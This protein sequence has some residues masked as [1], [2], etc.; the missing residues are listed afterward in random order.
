[1]AKKK[2]VKKKATKKKATKKKCS[3]RK[4][5]KRKSIPK[6]PSGFQN[7]RS[8]LVPVDLGLVP[9]PTSKIKTGLKKAQDEIKGM[10]Q[11]I[12]DTMTEDYSIKE[13]ELMA[14]FSADGKFLGIGVG[15]ATS[16]KITIAPENN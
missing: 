15:G 10:I 12:I 1:M 11:G 6:T 5:A 13:I 16:I 4:V 7:H 2:A 3:K 9:V 14:S 8:V